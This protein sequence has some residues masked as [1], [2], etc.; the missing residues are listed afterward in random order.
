MA[1]RRRY[2]KSTTMIRFF[3]WVL[4]SCGLAWQVQQISNIYFEYQTQVD[5]IIE[6]PRNITMPGL[7]MCIQLIYNETILKLHYPQSEEL[8]D[9]KN[10]ENASFSALRYVPINV[11]AKLPT[12]PVKIFCKAPFP[13]LTPL[14]EYKSDPKNCEHFAKIKNTIHF[15]PAQDDFFHCSTFFFSP[16]LPSPYQVVKADDKDFYK[17]EIYTESASYLDI[18]VSNTNKTTVVAFI[19]NPMEILHVAEADSFNFYTEQTENMILTT[20]KIITE[21]LPSPYRTDCYD[22]TGAEYGRTGCIFDCRKARAESLCSEIWPWDV[23]ADV[24]CNRSFSLRGKNC[25]AVMGD[26]RCS[27]ECKNQCTNYW[28]STTLIAAIEKRTPSNLTKLFVRRP[29]GVEITYKYLARMGEIEYLCYIASCFGIWMGI[30]FLDITYLLTD[31]VNKWITKR[32]TR[33][34]VLSPFDKRPG[35]SKISLGSLRTA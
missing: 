34:L 6:S 13:E 22:Y 1:I 4:S 17:I 25:T 31:S 30:S 35:R 2:H 15:N 29:F 5:M 11:L 24:N 8:I 12:T 9:W 18:L 20:S 28:Y 19:H 27:D 14:E 26:N 16:T 7:T 23:P 10:K 3:C 33:I 21:L 32:E